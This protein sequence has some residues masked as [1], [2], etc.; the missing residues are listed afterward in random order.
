MASIIDQFPAFAPLASIP[1]IAN[2]LN[3]GSAQNWTADQFVGHLMGTEWWRS[4]S[5]TQRDWTGMQLG[6]PMEAQRQSGD[7]ALKILQMAAVE[8]IPLSLSQAHYLSVASISGGWDATKLQYEIGSFAQEGKDNPGTLGATQTSLQGIAASQGIAVSDHTAFDWAQKIAMGTADQKG[9]EEY[10]K[11]QAITSH[12][13]WENQL[14]QGLT[15]RQLADP[16]IQRAAQ[17]LE[18][19]PDAISLTDPKYD[20]TKQDA[21]GQK[22]PMSQSDWQ[23]HLMTDPRYGWQSTDNAKQAAYQMVDQ[24]QKSFGAQ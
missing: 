14:N 20:F 19:S 10:A 9:F 7:Q 17:T 2:L 24:L 13:Y 4:T 5:K 12:P 22:T 18:I 6:D 8:G 11:Q 21:K 15:V 23:T 16:Y 3:E 1:E